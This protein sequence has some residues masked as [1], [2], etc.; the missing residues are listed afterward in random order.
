MFL[1]KEQLHFVHHKV[2]VI[3]SLRE[4]EWSIGEAKDTE[5]HM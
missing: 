1:F 4:D 2:L 5:I 3:F